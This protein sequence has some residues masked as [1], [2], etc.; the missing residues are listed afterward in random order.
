MFITPPSH[1]E[2]SCDTMSLRRALIYAKAGERPIP[3]KY[4][5]FTLF[6]ARKGGYLSTQGYPTAALHTTGKTNRRCLASPVPVFS[7]TN[8]TLLRGKKKKLGLGTVCE[9]Y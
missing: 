4:G 3:A 8:V 1:Y 2:N 5:L 6:F 9:I 7:L